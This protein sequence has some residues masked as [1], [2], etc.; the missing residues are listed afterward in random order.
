MFTSADPHPFPVS[1]SR[2]DVLA[3]GGSDN[4]IRAMRRGGLASVRGGAY[5]DGDVWQSL[6]DEQR[7]RLLVYATVP[8]L[9]PG[10]VVSHAS[11]AVLHGLPILGVAPS[12]VHITRERSSGGFQRGYLHTHATTMSAGPTVVKDGVRLTS[13][14]R[15]V[16]DCAATMPFEA[17]VCIAD[18]ALYK[19]VTSTDELG[20]L[21]A[22]MAGRR[23]I[24]R[25]RQVLGFADARSES[26]GE[27]FSRVQMDR[28]GLPTPSLQFAVGS[29]DRFIG[30][31]DFAWK[32]YRTLGEFD[33]AAKYDSLISEDESLRVVLREERKRERAL[34]DAGWE[35]V[36]WGWTDLANYGRLAAQINAGFVRAARLH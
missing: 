22:A 15:T 8:R 34:I 5:L 27:S 11:A 26:C 16:I 30:R 2:R 23:G 20:A 18:A 7:H 1:I 33:G 4:L 19:R 6:Q 32:E 35:V 9:A 13:A 31:A 36:R 29:G 3:E 21:A 25:V 14:A 12:V 10:A 24:G 17:A 28:A